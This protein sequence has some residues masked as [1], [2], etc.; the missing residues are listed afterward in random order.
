MQKAQP[1]F[2]GGAQIHLIAVLP[3]AARGDIAIPDRQPAKTEHH[4]GIARNRRPIRDLAEQ[5]FIGAKDMRQQRLRRRVG[6]GIHLAG[7]AAAK[8]QKALQLAARVMK[9]PCGGPAIGPA[10]DGFGAGF[11]AHTAGFFRHQP[12]CL[13]P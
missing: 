7:I 5:H 12:H 6:I 10:H 11:G 3:R 9:P 13:V 2:S 8:P 4:L 1:G